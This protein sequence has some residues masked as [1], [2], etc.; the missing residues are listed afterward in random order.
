MYGIIYYLGIFV[1]VSMLIGSIFL[2]LKM[3]VIKSFKDVI[4]YGSKTK[5]SGD[6]GLKAMPLKRS[7]SESLSSKEKEGGENFKKDIEETVLLRGSDGTVLLKDCYSN[8]SESG[9]KIIEEIDIS[10]VR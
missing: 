8:N 5:W 6:K 3:N 2:W 7:K 4:S 9:F 1:G 10:K